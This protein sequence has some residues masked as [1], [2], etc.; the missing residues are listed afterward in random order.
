MTIYIDKLIVSLTT[1][2]WVV[3]NVQN[4][5][6]NIIVVKCPKLLEKKTKYG[7]FRTMRQYLSPNLG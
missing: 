3:M 1:V 7:D 6:L 2:L 4:T 5:M